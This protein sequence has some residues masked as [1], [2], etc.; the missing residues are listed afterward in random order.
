MIVRIDKSFQKD[1]DKINDA[2]IKHAIIEAIHLIQDTEN[3][4]SIKNLKKLTGYKDLYRIRLGNYRIGLR[5]TYDQ[6]LIF[7]RFLHRKDIYQKW[8]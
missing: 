7:I 6:E 5:Y 3:F 8:P 4:S 2:K 1:V